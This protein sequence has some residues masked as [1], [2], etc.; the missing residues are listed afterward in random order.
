M[1]QNSSQLHQVICLSHTWGRIRRDLAVQG[2]WISSVCPSTPILHLSSY[3]SLPCGA[4]QHGLHRRHLCSL[5]FCR[6]WEGGRAE[7]GGG[8]F[9]SMVL[10]WKVA[11]GCC[12]SQQKVTALVQ[13]AH[14]ILL[15]PKFRSGQLSFLYTWR[16]EIAS[17][18]LSLMASQYPRTLCNQSLRFS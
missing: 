5:A 7:H 9:I 15:S 13:V 3:H 4:V 16:A 6:R 14:S 12:V 18:L 10:S 1:F 2:C 11:T 17:P 8:V